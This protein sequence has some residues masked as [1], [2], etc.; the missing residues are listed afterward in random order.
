MRPILSLPRNLL[1]HGIESKSE[2]LGNF[3]RLL[4]GLFMAVPTGISFWC[5]LS[6]GCGHPI[7]SPHSFIQAHAVWH[8]LGA[9]ALWWVYDFFSQASCREMARD[10]SCQVPGNIT[11]NNRALEGLSLLPAEFLPVGSCNLREGS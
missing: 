1:A 8:V 11:Q 9:G 6:D 10:P 3:E 2:W 5:R 7:C 4:F